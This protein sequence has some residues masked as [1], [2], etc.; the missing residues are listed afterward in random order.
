[1]PPAE[2]RALALPLLGREAVTLADGSTLLDVHE[3]RVDWNGGVRT[4]RVQAA[5][6]QPLLGTE[7]LRGHDLTIRM[8]DGGPVTIAAIP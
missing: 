2:I 1:M 3:G 7:M 6:P 8:I 4:V 5:G